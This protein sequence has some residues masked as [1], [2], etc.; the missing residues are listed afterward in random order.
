M[1][2]NYQYWS[3]GDRG[4]NSMLCQ[5]D[6]KGLFDRVTEQS[7]EEESRLFSN[8]EEEDSRAVSLCTN[9]LELTKAHQAVR[10]RKNEGVKGK[11]R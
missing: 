6:R 11:M 5:Q 10:L 4:N 2:K 3:V 1:K 9:S 7:L 8:L